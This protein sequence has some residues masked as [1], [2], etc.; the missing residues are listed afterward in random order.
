[1]DNH[2]RTDPV[3]TSD[4]EV[5]QPER[6]GPTKRASRRSA[7]SVDRRAGSNAL[8]VVAGGRHER[9]SAPRRTREDLR[10]LLVEAGTE[11]LWDEGLA[12]GAE[13]VTFKR[14]FE[15]VEGRSGVR[16]THASVIGRIWQNQ[17]EFQT[18][19]LTKVAEV[20]VLDVDAELAASLSGLEKFDRSTV[21]ARWR[22]ALEIC[23]VGGEATF[24]SML[25]SLPWSRWMAIWAL[26]VVDSGSPRK[27]PIVELLLDGES[28][29]TDFYE[30]TYEAAMRVLGLRM[31]ESFTV[32]QLALAIV[33]FSQGCA[34]RAGV[35]ETA[36]QKI[37][38]PTG[39]EGTEQPWTLFAVGLAALIECFVE[40][41]P[42]WVSA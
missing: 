14:V 7:R 3:V 21:E 32:R 38:R 37:D 33:A 18:E 22:A 24:N 30:E 2:E 41:D 9:R 26:A 12:A 15:R 31:R 28:R 35:D 8:R 10:Q 19:V 29:A 1:M 42:N 40:V 4:R 16:V 6:S 13:H 25:Q 5:H 27:K 36:S 11:I 39:P 17:D 20:N 34:L 23:R